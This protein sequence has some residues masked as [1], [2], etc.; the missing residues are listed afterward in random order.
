MLLLLGAQLLQYLAILRGGGG[1]L[2]SVLVGQRGEIGS[3]FLRRGKR[4]EY[5]GWIDRLV[6]WLGLL[7][8]WPSG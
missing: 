5:I 1:V 6:D 2:V 4:G 3:L 7:S 8:G